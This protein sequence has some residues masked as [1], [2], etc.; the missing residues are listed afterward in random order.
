MEKPSPDTNHPQLGETIK[1]V[2]RRVFITCENRIQLLVVEVQEERD[3]LLQSI[4]LGLAAAAFGLLG[5]ITLTIIVAVAFWEHSP[6]IALL[7]LA[8]VYVIA[9]AFFCIKLMRLQ[10]DSPA[11]AATI[12]Q[13]KKDRECLEKQL[14]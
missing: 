13:L 4:W 9:A 3:R 10:H 6:V 8:A 12:E 7:V 11:L 1:R 5:G 14:G 2:A